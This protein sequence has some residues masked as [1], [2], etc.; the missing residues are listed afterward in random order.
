M[1]L[2]TRAKSLSRLLSVRLPADISAMT[3]LLKVRLRREPRT[4]GPGRAPAGKAL[5]HRRSR[6]GD[7]GRN[8]P[9]PYRRDRGE[10]GGGSAQLFHRESGQPPRSPARSRLAYLRINLTLGDPVER[11]RHSRVALVKV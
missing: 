4:S 10:P 9:S 11:H 7:G 1:P 3:A 5:V 2:S 6:D 8:S